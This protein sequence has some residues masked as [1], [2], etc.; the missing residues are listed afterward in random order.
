MTHT[1]WFNGV[2]KG[3]FGHGMGLFG[4]ECLLTL[5]S[6]CELGEGDL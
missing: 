4:F 1:G 2:G 5:W 6:L 3:M